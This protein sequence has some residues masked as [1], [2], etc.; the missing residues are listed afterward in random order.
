MGTENHLRSCV[1]I[2]FFL[3]MVIVRIIGGLGNQMF[4]YAAGRGISMRNNDKLKLDLTPFD[5]YK[6]HNYSL[7]SL[8]LASTEATSQEVKNFK[9]KRFFSN[10]T[11]KVWRRKMTRPPTRV[12]EK[13][14]HFDRD[15]LK[16]KGDI[17]LDG[18]WQS[19]KYFKDIE[20]TIRKDFS[21]SYSPSSNAQKIKSMIQVTSCSVS[22]HIRRG[23]YVRNLKTRLI[24]G[25][26][27]SDYYRRALR[28]LSDQGI[29]DPTIFVFSDDIE[30]VN[31]QGLFPNA[32]FVSSYDMCD[33]EE[34]M[35]M[36]YCDHHI[37]ANSSFSWWGAWLNTS[38]EKI[39][40]APKVWFQGA[41]NDT[42][43]LIP[44][45][46]VRM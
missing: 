42:S 41:N 32:V 5:S 28:Y 23:D 37:I 21:P 12:K 10:V 35:L 25:I 9:K 14:F 19:E 24:H 18:Y 11:N 3:D 7:N 26:C 33:T 4:Q 38:Q 22:V 36:S 31:R 39:V 15:I 43:D 29:C 16:L 20:D 17:Y 40:I 44:D 27:S 13:H 45:T 1:N 6:L 8:S 46:W 30:W 2:T 34:I